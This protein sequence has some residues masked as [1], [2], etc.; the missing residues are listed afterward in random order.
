MLEEIQYL[1]SHLEVKEIS[2]HY[3]VCLYMV[4]ETPHVCKEFH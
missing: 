1:Y 3:H 2:N 4:E